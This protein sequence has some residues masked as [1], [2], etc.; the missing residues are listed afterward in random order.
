MVVSGREI[1]NTERDN[2]RMI[3]KSLADRLR[4]LRAQRGLTVKD[5]AQQVGVDRHTLRRIELGTQEA[6]Y[7]TLAKIAE[8]YSVPIE[9]LIEESAVVGKAEALAEASQETRRLDEERLEADSP[10]DRQHWERVLASV[11]E[12]QREVEAKVEELVALAAHSKADLYQVAW[13]LDEAQD[14]VNTLKLALPGIR[15]E[16]DKI[17]LKIDP[18]TVDV[19]QFKEWQQELRKAK[20]F[21]DDIVEKLV[22]AGLVEWKERAGQK[23]EPVPVGIG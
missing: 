11:R 15:R 19:D 1:P 13:A 4:L 21:Y 5:A 16:Q 22:E 6:Q 12:R 17:I 9:E 7:P 20:R 2:Q 3:Q 18:L 8:G 10:K 23:A 14:C